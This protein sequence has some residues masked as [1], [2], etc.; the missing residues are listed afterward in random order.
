M[1]PGLASE[2]VHRPGKP[3]G[4]KTSGRRGGRVVGLA[5]ELVHRP[6]KPAG[7]ETTLQVP[8]RAKATRSAL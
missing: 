5:G 7:V 4:V 2:L 3:A 1:W 8:V 6:G